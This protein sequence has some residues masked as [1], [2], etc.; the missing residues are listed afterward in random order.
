MVDGDIQSNRSSLAA[1]EEKLAINSNAVKQWFAQQYQ[2]IIPPFYCSV[3]VRYAGFKVSPVDTN[4]FPAGFNNLSSTSSKAVQ[5]EMDSYMMHYYPKVRHILL[6]P[7]DFT[8]NT[9]YW[10]NL[11]ALYTMLTEAGYKV[12]C[13]SLTLQ[14]EL[15]DPLLGHIVVK[16]LIKR[17]HTLLTIDQ[18]VPDLVLL[19]NDLLV[20]IP[21][22]LVDITQPVIPMPQLGW[23]RR[24][25]HAHF[26]IYQQVVE[27]FGRA[28]ECDPWLLGCYFA[29]STEVDFK[30]HSG[31]EAVAEAVD[32]VLAKIAMKYKQ[33]NIDAKPYA[34]VKADNGTFGMGVMMV[35]SGAE[36]LSINKHRRHSMN[37]IKYGVANSMLIIQEGVPTIYNHIEAPA[38]HVP[39]LVG[40]KVVAT[41]MR[42]NYSRDNL[43][44]LNSIG[45]TVEECTT[46]IRRSE[47]LVAELAAL[48]A[49]K[50]AIIPNLAGR[51][52]IL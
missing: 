39:Y 44:N 46:P 34:Y 24:R 27:E 29:N 2:G 31:L 1:L 16:P 28:F 51:C 3:D 32:Q 20:G 18:W 50:E 23:H 30:H 48:A 37:S 40:G 10:R 22:L 13:G 8:R 4:L 11:H 9:W 7:E 49:A 15:S 36:V 19:N 35:G 6:V 17:N 42:H 26:S 43:T 33:Y 5:H 25:K 41:L 52:E 21:N 12:R 14:A 47:V 38:E 45:A